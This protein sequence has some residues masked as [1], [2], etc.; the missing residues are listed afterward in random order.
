MQY[1]ATYSNQATLYML[2]TTNACKPHFFLLVS[3]SVGTIDP[4][5]KT[6]GIAKVMTFRVSPPQRS[7]AGATVVA[8]ASYASIVRIHYYKEREGEKE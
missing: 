1:I 5:V 8:L 7:V 6:T 3:L 2:C 4:V